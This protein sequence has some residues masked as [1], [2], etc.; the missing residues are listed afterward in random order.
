[1]A[2]RPSGTSSDTVLPSPRVARRSAAAARARPSRR[3]PPRSRSGPVGRGGSVGAQVV[4]SKERRPPAGRG[5]RR[6][7]RC[8]A[9]RRIALVPDVLGRLKTTP[10]GAT[11]WARMSRAGA[12]SS[13]GHANPDKARFP[14]PRTGRATPRL[15]RDA[16][17]RTCERMFAG[18]C[19]REGNLGPTPLRQQMLTV[20]KRRAADRDCAGP[21]M[22]GCPSH[23][24]LCII[25][26]RT[27][28][29]ERHHQPARRSR[30]LR[31]LAGLTHPHNRRRR[32]P[33]QGAAALPCVRRRSPV[34]PPRRSA[35][36]RACRPCVRA[37]R[38]ARRDR[39]TPRAYR[40]RLCA[41]RPGQLSG[42]RRAPWRAGARW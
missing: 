9:G 18:T 30:P 14:A 32:F 31:R 2:R 38:T 24:S 19:D 28:L 16:N 34:R 40:A 13:C 6:L 25:T 29:Y 41:P 10:R 11:T 33:S 35:P 4:S 20:R 22:Y 1:M 42:R 17:T 27:H 23:T 39:S 3:P 15:D 37:P 7:V 5:L 21:P 36:S 12:R 26:R 8:I